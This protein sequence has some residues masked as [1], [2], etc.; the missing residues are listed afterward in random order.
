MACPEPKVPREVSETKEVLCVGPYETTVKEHI[1]TA[2]KN[3]EMLKNYWEKYITDKVTEH[4]LQD[5]GLSEERSIQNTQNIIVNKLPILC[6][7]SGEA[8]TKSK[9]VRLHDRYFSK[10]DENILMLAF[11]LKDDSEQRDSEN[12]NYIQIYL[13]YENDSRVKYEQVLSYLHHHCCQCAMFTGMVGSVPRLPGQATPEIDIMH[14]DACKAKVIHPFLHDTCQNTLLAQIVYNGHGSP[15]GLCV[16]E[17][18]TIKLDDIISDVTKC[19]KSILRNKPPIQ[20]NIIFAQCYGNRFTGASSQG[21]RMMLDP[22]IPTEAQS[23]KTITVTHLV[24]RNVTFSMP[25]Y[26]AQLEDYAD[27]RNEVVPDFPPETPSTN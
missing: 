15:E 7:D 13:H 17:D 5:H 24:T 8:G 9:I 23:D 11:P 12:R 10:K 20:V 19:F 26:H 2:N 6:S 4:F 27:K 22:D 3:I 18:K 16:H 25:G 1:T 14:Q 21:E